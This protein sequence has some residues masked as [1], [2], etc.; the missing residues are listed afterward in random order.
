M[1]GT[2]RAAKTAPVGAAESGVDLGQPSGMLLALETI[3]AK[4]PG[5]KAWSSDDI[6]ALQDCA[7]KAI[8]LIKRNAN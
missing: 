7:A 4:V 6:V 5:F 1:T 2:G 3:R 8:A